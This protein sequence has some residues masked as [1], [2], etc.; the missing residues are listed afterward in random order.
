[1]IANPLVV[2]Y[3][4][5][6]GSAILQGLL[7]TTDKALN[8][9]C[10]DI[11]E[12]EEEIIE[13]IQ[14]SQN[15][16]LCVPIDKTIEWISKYKGHLS[17]KL[18]YEQCSLKSKILKDPV[19]KGLDIISMH[20]LFRPSQTPNREDRHIAI[21]GRDNSE[22]KLLARLLQALLDAECIRFF[23]TP[24]IHDEEMAYQQALVHRVI[25]CLDEILLMGVGTTYIG[26]KVGE[27]ASRI[28]K[29][30]R[31]LYDFI[32]SNDQLE[33]PLSE[34]IEKF[35]NFDIKKYMKR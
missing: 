4:G 15:I 18:I 9:F 29:G 13:R 19:F 10:I 32:Q 8:I 7:R 6:I 30:D 25:L 16:F 17:G 34:F 12:T 21:V 3:K 23:E 2:G 27:L 20:I 26:K 14:K 1:M 5:E 22:R 24:E 11:N 35:N 31:D 28:K 33:E